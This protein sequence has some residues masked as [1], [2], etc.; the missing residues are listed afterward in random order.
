MSGRGRRKVFLTS[1]GRILQVRCKRKG[2]TPEEKRFVGLFI[3]FLSSSSIVAEPKTSSKRPLAEDAADKAPGVKRRRKTNKEAETEVR[4]AGSGFCPGRLSQIAPLTWSGRPLGGE[5]P[6]AEEK[7]K[8]TG[9]GRDG[10]ATGKT[11][12]RPRR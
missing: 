7:K 11:R 8:K 4:S 3:F 2:T 5:R 12:P 1:T 6:K 10:Q 9:E